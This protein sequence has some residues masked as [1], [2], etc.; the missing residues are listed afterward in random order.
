MENG[1]IF[2]VFL[3]PVCYN[4]SVAMEYFSLNK[5]QAKKLGA[6][7]HDEEIVTRPR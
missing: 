4:E 7:W 5:E 1:R 6:G 3:A 2:P